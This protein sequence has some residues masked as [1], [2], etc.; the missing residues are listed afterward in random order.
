VQGHKTAST[1]TVRNF[2]S[3]PLPPGKSYNFEVTATWPRD[4]QMV[5]EKRTV[6]VTAGATTVVDLAGA[7][8]T[9]PEPGSAPAQ[10][11]LPP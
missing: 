10:R 7:T 11:E 9:A 5:T 3:P 1:G 6:P 4:G 8:S 2:E